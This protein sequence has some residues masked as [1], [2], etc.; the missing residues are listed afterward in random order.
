MEWAKVTFGKCALGDQRRNARLINLA[1]QAAARPN[2][3][4][5]VGSPHGSGILSALPCLENVPRRPRNRPQILLKTPKE[6]W[7]IAEVS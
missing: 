2:G 3:S 6:M 1:E 5:P 7:V 4:T